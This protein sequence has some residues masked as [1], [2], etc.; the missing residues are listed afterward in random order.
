MC[1]NV[2]LVSTV[3]ASIQVL[4]VQICLFN[5]VWLTYLIHLGSRY[6][7]DGLLA[8]C[9][10]VLLEEL[11]HSH[12]W[13]LHAD[14]WVALVRQ[15]GIHTDKKRERCPH[16]AEINWKRMWASLIFFFLPLHIN[17]FPTEREEEAN[18]RPAG[19]NFIDVALQ[20]S[21]GGEIKTPPF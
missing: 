17:S 18:S 11:L 5:R 16:K 20:H 19:E 21:V 3:S 7:R 8:V 13:D 14:H 15:P 9:H 2:P 10:V 12:F 4:W 1:L 6:S